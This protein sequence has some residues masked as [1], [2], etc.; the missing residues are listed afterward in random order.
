MNEEDN[1]AEDED[2]E[3][4]ESRPTRIRNAPENYNPT[5]GKSYAQAAKLDGNSSWKEMED[6]HDSGWTKV[7]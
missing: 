7:T 2:E 3:E 4:V 1:D 6:D 5:T